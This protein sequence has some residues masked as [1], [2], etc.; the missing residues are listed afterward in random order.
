M[1][2]HSEI[3]LIRDQQD[4]RRWRKLVR[5]VGYPQDASDTTVSLFWDDATNTPWIRLD[6]NRSFY[7]RSF[8]EVIDSIH[9]DE[10]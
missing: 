6:K 7:G 10:L 2:D 3:N 9:E 1:G 4:A 5:L 8:E